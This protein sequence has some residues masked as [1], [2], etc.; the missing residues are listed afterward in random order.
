MV[1]GFLK[2][3]SKGSA[4]GNY[5]LMDLVAGLHWLRENIEAFGGDSERLALLG[6]G[7]GAA[8]ANFLAKEKVRD[9]KKGGEGEKVGGRGLG[10]GWGEG[11]GGSS[12]LYKEGILYTHP[13]GTVRT[14]TVLG[15]ASGCRVGRWVSSSSFFLVVVVV[16]V[17]VTVTVAV[18]VV[19]VVVVVVWY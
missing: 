17:A 3:G 6:H 10:E 1:V 4:Q 9:R 11:W 8:L 16:A 13:I 15:K 2:T 18:A 5:G 12:I 19:V 14:H 7:T